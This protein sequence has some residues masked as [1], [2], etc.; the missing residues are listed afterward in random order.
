MGSKNKKLDTHA[1]TPPEGDIDVG[2]DADAEPSQAIAVDAYPMPRQREG[3]KLEIT[4]SDFV[5]PDEDRYWIGLHPDCPLDIVTVGGY[6][7]TKVT[8]DFELRGDR[9]KDFEVEGAIVLMTPAR[10]ETLKRAI[11]KVG[12][13]AVYEWDDQTQ[14]NEVVRA[15]QEKLSMGLPPAAKW[16]YIV[17][18]DGETLGRGLPRPTLLYHDPDDP[19]EGE[20]AA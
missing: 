2:H 13:D 6:A 18:F 14:R 20:K 7:F 17:R 12:I 16:M 11:V 8:N 19:V 4:Q 3:L 9:W 10:L 5:K 1:P 15:T